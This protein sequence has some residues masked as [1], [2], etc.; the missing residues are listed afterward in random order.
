MFSIY[1]F[2]Q[3]LLFTGTLWAQY[4]NRYAL[5][6]QMVYLCILLNAVVILYKSFL[7]RKN[8]SP[9]S[10]AG[11]HTILPPAILLL[12]LCADTLLVLLDIWHLAGVALFGCVH[13][14]YAVYLIPERERFL[15]RDLLL[16]FM[17]LIALLLTVILSGRFSLLAMAAAFS[18]SQLLSGT[19]LSILIAAKTRARRDHLLATGL[20]LFLACDICV[21]LRNAEL[22]AAVEDAAYMLNWIFYIPSQFLI[23]YS[24]L[25]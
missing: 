3:A 6:D 12:T 17:L 19:F 24:F 11:M 5:T 14:L 13:I 20:L 25:L 22:S 1:I 9:V 2:T 16:R 4:T 8:R 18:F 23:T 7:T 21:G 15:L 10:V